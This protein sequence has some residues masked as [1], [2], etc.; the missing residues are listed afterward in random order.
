M[1]AVCALGL[2]LAKTSRNLVN[3]LYL[4]NFEGIWHDRVVVPAF[5]E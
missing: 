2:I 4:R 3:S 1:M 5:V